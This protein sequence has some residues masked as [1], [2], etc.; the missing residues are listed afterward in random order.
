MTATPWLRLRSV[1]PTG[2]GLYAGHAARGRQFVAALRRGRPRAAPWPDEYG[3]GRGL[4]VRRGRGVRS[5]RMPTGPIQIGSPYGGTARS[6][7]PPKRRIPSL[8]AAGVASAP[9]SDPYSGG[10]I[11][12]SPAPARDGRPVPT[13]APRPGS[14]GILDGCAA[15][16]PERGPGTGPMSQRL[17]RVAGAQDRHSRPGPAYEPPAPRPGTISA[18]PW[19]AGSRRAQHWAARGALCPIRASGPG[20]SVHGNGLDLV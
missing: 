2:S 15:V 6:G 16:L 1:L 17:A 7:A 3:K 13:T 18:A 5:H 19:H 8:T 9:R 4:S 11:G 12:A 20:F 10:S 14:G